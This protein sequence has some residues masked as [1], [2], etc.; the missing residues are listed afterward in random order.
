MAAAQEASGSA[1]KAAATNIVWAGV[2]ALG[3]SLIP[4]ATFIVL[5]RLLGPSAFGLANVALSVVQVLQLS[6]ETLFHDA[7]VQRKD[8]RPSHVSSAIWAGFGIGVIYCGLCFLVATPLGDFYKAPDLRDALMVMGLSLLPTGANGVR[9]AMLRREMQFARVAARSVIGRLAGAVVGLSLGLMGHGIWAIVWQQVATVLAVTVALWSYKPETLRFSFSWR[10]AWQLARVSVPSSAANLILQANLRL[11]LLAV[12]YVLG[13]AAAGQLSVGVRIVDTAR[14]ILTT[15]LHQLA[16]PLFVR[17]QR[18]AGGIANG[19]R[20]ATELTCLATLPL[21]AGLFAVADHLV[22]VILG[23]EWMTS[24]VIIQILCVLAIVQMMRL[25]TTAAIVAVGRPA[26]LVW[27]NGAGL[28]ASLGLVY[29]FGH[30]GIVAVALIWTGRVVITTPYNLVTLKRVCDIG[31]R[32]QII[33]TL[34]PLAASVIMAA[35]V[36]AVDVLWLSRQ[37]DIL[38]LTALVALGGLLYAVSVFLLDR[39]SILRIGG[40]ALEVLRK[41]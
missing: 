27:Q 8:L 41:R 34:A 24:V 39:K 32:D 23:R 9:T 21:F 12:G 10:R 2:E 22:P 11:F 13:A 7:I 38:A 15:A 3:V 16:L 30:Y 20:Q 29:A 40:F 31:Y 37:P 5:A 4:L 17:K 6:S 33:P 35:G 28:A 26:L 36:E 14:T 25:Y 1:R 19:F 18:E